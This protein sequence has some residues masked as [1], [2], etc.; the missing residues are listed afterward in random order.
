MRMRY[1]ECLLIIWRFIYCRLLLTELSPCCVVCIDS[2]SCTARKISYFLWRVI[3]L[4]WLTT[5][6]DGRVDLSIADCRVSSF[7]G[8]VCHLFVFSTTII[9]SRL[10]HDYKQP[11]ICY[12]I[13]SSRVTIMEDSW[14]AVDR[15]NET[16]AAAAS[17]I[18]LR[19]I[20]AE[21]CSA[22]GRRVHWCNTYYRHR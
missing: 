18:A 21:R 2:A 4:F 14:P 16:V 22:Y 9:T 1:I 20:N 12:T 7:C 8:F 17:S 10:W 15:R 6:H 11:R 13:Q 5:P 3:I 19:Q